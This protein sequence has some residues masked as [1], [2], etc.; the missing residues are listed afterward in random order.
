MENMP[1]AEDLEHLDTVV[2]RHVHV[3]DH[4]VVVAGRPELERA[5]AVVSGGDAI[6][7]RLQEIEEEICVGAVVVC[8]QNPAPHCAATRGVLRLAAAMWRRTSL[9]KVRV[10]IGLAMYPWHPASTAS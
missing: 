1:P 9:P 5:V 6:A 4:H 8:D 10:S 2:K 3:Q 7:V